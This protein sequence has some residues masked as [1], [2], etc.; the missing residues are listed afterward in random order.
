MPPTSV[1]VDAPTAGASRSL[2]RDDRVTER[3]LE[4]R[5]RDVVRRRELDPDADPAAVREV[6][7]EVVEAHQ[8]SA[9]A[10]RA[11]LLAD[12]EGVRRRLVDAVSGLGELQQY[13]DDPEVEEIWVNSRVRR[14]NFLLGPTE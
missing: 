9:G 13:L 5:V 12:E 6:V 8:Q 4:E 10:G 2:P 3:V 11:S 1:E 7:A 14:Q